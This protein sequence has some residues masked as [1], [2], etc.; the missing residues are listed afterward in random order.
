MLS[1]KENPT[2]E[3]SSHDQETECIICGGSSDE[4]W[5]QCNSCKDWAL[6]HVNINKTDLY[7]N[8]EVC[9]AKKRFGH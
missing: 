3:P 1:N 8:S 6:R 7:Y 5:I 4:D 2:P 9:F